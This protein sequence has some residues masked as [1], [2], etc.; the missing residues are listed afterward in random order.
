MNKEGRISRI[1]A[2]FATGQVSTEGESTVFKKYTGV[3]PF[4]I[5]A[6]N[7]DLATIKQFIPNY[8]GKEPEYLIKKDD[9]V[10]STRICFMLK[11]DKSLSK[12]EVAANL[13]PANGHY[14]KLVGDNDLYLFTNVFLSGDYKFNSD[15]TKIQVI[16]NYGDTVWVETGMV[17]GQELP[18]YAVN[19]GYLLPYKPARI[20]E[21][22]LIDII[23]SFLVIPITKDFDNDNKV[24]ITKPTDKLKACEASFS[25][26]DIAAILKGDVRSIRSV[27]ASQ[28]NNSIKFPLAIRTSDDNKE[29]QEVVSR[30]PIQFRTKNYNKLAKDIE[31]AKNSGAFSTLNF[32]DYSF[33]AK[34]YNSNPTSFTAPAKAAVD[35]LPWG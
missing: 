14:A 13:E 15:K 3:F 19:N 32:G 16:N 9:K 27:I 35:D 12:D 26:E 21:D 8:T 2:G 6:V 11:V 20:G 28:V 24:W 29:Y 33:E 7:P 10:D 31:S 30:F 1:Y 25:D 22:N 17:K 5:V 4:K 23:K 18:E 34:E